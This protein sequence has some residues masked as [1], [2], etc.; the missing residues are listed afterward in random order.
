ME[1]LLM[2]NGEEG[3]EV[4]DET[5]IIGKVERRARDKETK[6]QMKRGLGIADEEDGL[7]DDE[8][9]IDKIVE[10][11]ISKLSFLFGGGGEYF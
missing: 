11:V 4:L 10:M 5:N 6:M 9:F 3:D 7:D 8:T 2:M 1:N